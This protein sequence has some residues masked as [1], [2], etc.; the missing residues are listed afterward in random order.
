MAAI[1]VTIVDITLR[2][3]KCDSSASVID[4]KVQRVE[5]AGFVTRRVTATLNAS[6]SE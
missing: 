2:V 6:L 1:C 5:N 3:M 4:D